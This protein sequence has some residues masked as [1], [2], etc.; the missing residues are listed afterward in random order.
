MSEN[1]IVV[2]GLRTRFGNV[3]ALD[4]INLEVPP[5]AVFGLLGLNGAGR[6]RQYASWPR[7]FAPTVA[8]HAV[9]GLR[10]PPFA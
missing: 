4:G 7:C 10:A 3:A 6:R 8:F 1:A 5:G 2:D 9:V